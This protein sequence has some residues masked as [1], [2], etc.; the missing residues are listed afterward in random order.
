[1]PAPFGFGV[2]DIIEGI[3]LIVAAVKA[4]D[5]ANGAKKGYREFVECLTS[6]LDNFAALDNLELPEQLEQSRRAIRSQVA[7][8]RRIISDFVVTTTKYQR[9][10]SEPGLG[11]TDGIRKIQWQLC[12]KKDLDLFHESLRRQDQDLLTCLAQVNM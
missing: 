7:R 8:I 2:S 4:L 11:W 6:L 5:D 3:T 1:M 9:S 10:L 12:K